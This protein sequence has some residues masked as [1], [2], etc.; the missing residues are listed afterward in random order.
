MGPGFES[1]EVHQIDKTR[2]LMLTGFLFPIIV[3]KVP[4]FFNAL[5]ISIIMLVIG[6]YHI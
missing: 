3:I 4:G 5:F 6:E 1:L 2:K